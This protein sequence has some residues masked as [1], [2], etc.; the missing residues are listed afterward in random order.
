MISTEACIARRYRR[1]AAGHAR[2]KKG[3]SRKKGKNGGGG[4]RR[5]HCSLFCSPTGARNIAAAQPLDVL[6][7]YETCSVPLPFSPPFLRHYR[8]PPLFLAVLFL[9]LV[10]LIFFSIQCSYTAS[11]EGTFGASPNLDLS[12]LTAYIPL[13][14]PWIGGPVWN[15]S[16]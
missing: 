3:R 6:V 15:P 5:G 8:V 10:I 11:N 14:P 16:R 4:D 13:S 2:K 12:R 7:G 1:S 9:L